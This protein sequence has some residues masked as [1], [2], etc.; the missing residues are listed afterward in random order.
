MLKPLKTEQQGSVCPVRNKIDL[1]LPP[2]AVFLNPWQDP[3]FRLLLEPDFIWRKRETSCIEGFAVSDHVEINEK[4]KN[5]L[6]TTKKKKRF[7]QP[8]EYNSVP[9]VLDRASYRKSYALARDRI[10]LSGASGT[11]ALNQYCW[12]N[13]D[14][15]FDPDARLQEYF[16]TCR[17]GN[18]GKEIPVYS[19]LLDPD[20]PFAIACRN[21]FNYYHFITESLSQLTVLDGLDF[22]GNI[23]FHF[24][25]LEEKQKPFAQNFV[26]ALF[27]E[28][29]GRVFFER[30]PKDYAKVLTAYDLIGGHYQAPVGDVSGLG[31]LWPEDA[32]DKGDDTS[33]GARATLAMNAVNSSL[34]ALRARA[35]RA[36]EGRAFDHL[37]KRFFVG[38]DSRQSRA[39]NM[40]GE[41]ILFEHLDMFGFEYVVFESLSP[42]EQIALMARAEVM[43]SYHGAGFTN[44]LFAAQ[45]TFVIE[46]GTLQTARTRWADFWP[47]AHAAQCRY[48]NFFADF[49][50]DTPLIEPDFARDG[51]VP[52]ALSKK[53]V[54]QII[55]FIVT[56]AGKYPELKRPRLLGDLASEVLQ[57]GAATQAIGLLEAHAELVAQ[58]GRLCLIKADCHKAL[59]EPKSELLALDMAYKADPSRWQT[60]IRM[61][62]CANHCDRPQVIR[63]ALSRLKVDFPQRHDAFLG[64]HEWVRYVA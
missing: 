2:S 35:L 11:R 64:N 34:L 3:G 23:Y 38:R 18:E 46:I 45:T 8:I 58:N 5:H 21:T 22:Q 62:W 33:P 43:V 14:A 50:S 55:A 48:I 37:P 41:E 47:L 54:S 40:A 25:N 24:P 26:D 17:A 49:K 9:V 31:A 56:L 19:G 36:I 44:M 32:E 63:W 7:A 29:A 39:R 12:E 28:Y 15:A 27:P 60:L 42:L 52:V 20:I 16:A 61:I 51:I 13:E 59:G 1:T 53:S 4:I 30:V 10:L 6:R 57:V